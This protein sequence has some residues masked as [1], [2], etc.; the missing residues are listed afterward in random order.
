MAGNGGGGIWRMSGGGSSVQDAQPE[1][2]V[3]K[4]KLLIYY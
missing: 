1:L 2:F 4:S 3:V